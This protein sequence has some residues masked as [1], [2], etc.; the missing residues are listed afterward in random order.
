MESK[1]I[2]NRVYTHTLISEPDPLWKMLYT[3]QCILT[4]L[5]LNPLIPD[6]WLR[7]RRQPQG[8]GR[9]R[10]GRRPPRVPGQRLRRQTDGRGRGQ[11]GQGGEVHRGGAV[12]QDRCHSILYQERV[13]GERKELI[14]F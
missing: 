13:Q 9:D 2:K 11:G 12:V 3:L 1:D 10:V 8:R 6:P 5:C 7:P 14:V 4:V